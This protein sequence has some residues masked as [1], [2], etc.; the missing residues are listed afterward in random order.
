MQRQ[1]SMAVD[2]L[3]GLSRNG[4]KVPKNVEFFLAGGFVWNQIAQRRP[5]AVYVLI[6]SPKG[7]KRKR[8]RFNNLYEAVN[9]HRK[10]SPKYPSSG[11][12][13][14]GRAYDLPPEWRIRKEKLPRRFKWCP[15]CGAFRVFSKATP[16]ETFTTLKKIWSEDKQRYVWVERKVWLIECQLCG[17]TN[18]SDVYRRSNQPWEVRRIRQGR[19][20]VKPRVR[21]E[22]T[23]TGRRVKVKRKKR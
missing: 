3:L 7:T 14:L 19:K 2:A 5:W 1:R 18:R 16:E 23:P 17:H 10:I 12:V 15:H 20:R 11:V 9:F 13:S 8:K 6:S 4:Y 21:T 22:R